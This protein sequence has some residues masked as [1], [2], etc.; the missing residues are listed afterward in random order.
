[1]ENFRKLEKKGF[2]LKVC[3]EA[4]YIG[5]NLCRNLIK[6]NITCEIVAPSLIPEQP[7]KRIKTDRLDSKKLAEYYAKGLLT[8][9]YI[10]NEKDEKIRDLIRTRNF[11]IK[12]WKEKAPCR[13]GA[14]Q[15]RRHRKGAR[16][17]H[18]RIFQKE[19][20]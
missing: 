20:F 18:L 2:E 11:M 3:Y 8:P 7:G 9:I 17:T 19:K 15:K 16:L 14:L 13:K 1:M 6:N 12:Q 4:S 5:Y 10:P